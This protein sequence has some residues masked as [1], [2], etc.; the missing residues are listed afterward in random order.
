[1]QAATALRLSSILKK[2]L[3]AA[4]G[5]VLVAFVAGHLLGNL[6]MY[7]LLGGQ[8]AFNAYAY[9]LHHLP[10]GLLWVIRAFLLACVVV[11]V[12]MAILLTLE[13][14][15]ARPVLYEEKRAVQSTYAA[16]TMRWSGFILL[17]FILFHL[18]H[19]TAR[20]VP[21]MD[22]NDPSIIAPVPLM[23]HGKPVMESGEIVL[24]FDAYRMVILGFQNPWVSLFYIVSMGLLCLHLAHGVSSLFQSLGLR[25][26]LWR[27]RLDLVANVYGWGIFLGFISIPAS[28][29]AGLLA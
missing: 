22:Y 10:Y 21:G 13:N 29:L 26:K 14:R 27:Q 16:R 12:W 28:I 3:M 5:L 7:P 17:A 25:N 23:K 20:T 18:A 15:R 11:H 9:K 1:M 2:F 24:T 6:Q 19:Y 4:S 8:D